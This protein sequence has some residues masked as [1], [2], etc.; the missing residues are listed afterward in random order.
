MW[1]PN[2]TGCGHRV[3]RVLRRPIR[4]RPHHVHELA[5]EPVDGVAYPEAEIGRHLVV[6]AAPG[7]QPPAGV[8]DALGQPGL[9]VHVDV[10]ERIG[11]H[12]PPGGDVGG[13]RL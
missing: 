6:A 13:D 10:L 4:Q 12:E 7:M 11:E 1:C 5:V 2:V 8:A 9:D 3:R